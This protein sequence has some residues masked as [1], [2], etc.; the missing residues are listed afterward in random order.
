MKAHLN[1]E[2]ERLKKNIQILSSM[3]ESAVRNSVVAVIETDRKLAERVIENDFLIDQKEI[4]IEEECLKILAL[5]QPVAGDLRYVVACLKVNNELER[6][7]DLGSNI[8]RRV[9]HLCDYNG[10][11]TAVDFKPMMDVTRGMLKGALDSLICMNGQ[12]AAEVIQRDDIVDDYN[13]QMFIDLQELIKENP[14]KTEYYIDLLN[15]SRHL[16]RIA[17]CTTNI[18]EDIIYMIKGEIIRHGHYNDI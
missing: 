11:D 8:A 15:V 6:I 7:G 10:A 4:E 16:E 12:L 13:R 18:C 9:K 5:H 2:I 3:V 17:D 14:Q 1:K